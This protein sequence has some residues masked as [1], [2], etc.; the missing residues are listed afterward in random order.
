MT[1]RFI[2]ALMALGLLAPLIFS[3]CNSGNETA[4]TTPAAEGFAIYLTKGDVP[5]AQMEALSHVEIADQAV[6]SV[7]DIIS[8]TKSTHEIELTAEAFQRVGALQ[9]PTSGKS[10]V[11]CVNK[12]PIYWGAFWTP[13]SSQAFS[14]VTIMVPPFP[15]GELPANTIQIG[16]GY[17][18]ASFY[19]G[20]DPRSNPAIM[21]S[22]QAAGKL[23]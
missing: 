22:L 6:I 21:E 9:V 1:K 7:K 12:N 16:P 10:F 5:V 4:A 11:V 13:I 18:S 20:E 17:P 23:K 14:G 19:Q 2:M 3:G 8:Y 15:Y